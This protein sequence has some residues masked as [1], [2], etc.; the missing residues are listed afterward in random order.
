MTLILTYIR[1][2]TFLSNLVKVSIGAV[3]YKIIN[4]K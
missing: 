2:V 1:E 3:R 4:E